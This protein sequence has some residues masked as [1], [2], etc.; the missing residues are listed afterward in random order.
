MTLVGYTPALISRTA[1][2]TKKGEDDMTTMGVRWTYVRPGAALFGS[3]LVAVG[4]SG[5][6]GLPDRNSDEESLGTTQQA[7]SSAPA[8]STQDYVD[9]SGTIRVRVKTCDWANSAVVSTALGNFDDAETCCEIDPEFVMVGGGAEIEGEGSPGALLK[10]SHPNPNS[11]APFTGFNTSWLARSA[12]HVQP[13]AHRLRAYVIGLQLEGMT[14]AE[15]EAIRGQPIDSVT[16]SMT[17]PDPNPSVRGI[18]G[19]AS[20]RRLIGGGAETVFNTERLLMTE[21]YPADQQWVATTRVNQNVPHD[22]GTKTYTMAMETCPTGWDGCLNIDD[23][24][25]NAG[26]SSGY[27]TITASAPG[28]V[29]SI[30]ARAFSAP[31]GAGR[32]IHDLI[33]YPNNAPGFTVR[34]K[35]HG[36][37]DTAGM[38]GFAKVISRV[39]HDIVYRHSRKCLDVSGVSQTAGAAVVQWPCSGALNQRLYL[40]S[41]GGGF[42]SVRFRHSQQCLDVNQASTANGAAII[43]WPCTG[44][45]N[46]LF[47]LVPAANGGVAL[48]AMHS[49]KCVDV[50]NA[51]QANG[52]PL[53][54]WTCNGQANQTFDLDRFSAT[55]TETS[56]WGTGYCATLQV[57]NRSSLP[58]TNWSLKL[59]MRGAE[60][61]E[62]WNSTFSPSIDTVTITPSQQTWNTSIAP[63]ATNTSVGFCARERMMVTTTTDPFP[64]DFALASVLAA[65]PSY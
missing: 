35:N 42:Y 3:V 53:V 40:I 20:T 51:S 38:A 5:C 22:G 36:G 23:L 7:V 49:Q 8:V 28:L 1:F 65:T 46:Q 24:V 59:D 17:P 41:Q 21:S 6:G 58:T 43:Q 44:A 18:L 15:L 64:M 4:T 25:V 12:S 13:F 19:N 50:Q 47:E 32:Y 26:A 29:T 34:T 61:Y 30:G 48:R 16:T 54:Q 55:V 14:A 63:G 52:T 60:I 45:A 10:A 39:S 27:G 33:P 62:S 56:N 37:T 57:H 11:C 9:D 2:Q 31:G